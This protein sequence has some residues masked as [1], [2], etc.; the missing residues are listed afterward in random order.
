MSKESKLGGAGLASLLLGCLGFPV[1]GLNSVC[2]GFRRNL[3]VLDYY[4]LENIKADTE[5]RTNITGN[6]AEGK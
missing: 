5:M 6:E 2:L 1:F 3:G 4:R